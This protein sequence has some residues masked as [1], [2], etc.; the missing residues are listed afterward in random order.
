M[1]KQPLLYSVLFIALFSILVSCTKTNTNANNSGTFVY[2]K[3]SV[4][5]TLN[6]KDSTLYTNWVSDV[7]VAN[8]FYPGLNVIGSKSTDTK[9]NNGKAGQAISFTIKNYPGLTKD[10]NGNYTGN[11]VYN[12]DG[13]GV[14]G[15]WSEDGK[16]ESPAIWGVINIAN[17]NA[18]SASGTF[19]MVFADSTRVDNVS[20]GVL[21]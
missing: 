21:W 19:S 6:G 5:R 17:G 14:T 13:S 10:G 3:T 16:K 7:T 8:S 4:S 20:F 2:M 12:I 15:Y 11:G 9:D 18:Q 1:M